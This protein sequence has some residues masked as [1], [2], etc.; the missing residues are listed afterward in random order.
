MTRYIFI[1]GGVVS[2]LGKGL[3]SAALGVLLQERNYK[4]K[5][6]KLDPYLNV[7]A[8]TMNP[9]QH[10]EVF[11]TDDKV[12][13]DMDLGHYER[14]TNVNTTKNDIITAGKIYQTLL[15]KERKGDY[16]GSTVQTIPHVTNLIK[17][18]ILKDTDDV[19]FVLAEI[20]GTVGDIEGLPFFESIRQIGYELGKNRAIFIHLTLVPY[21]KTANELKTKPTQHSV[22]TLCSIGIQPDILLCRSDHHIPKS[23]KEKIAAF[24]NV[25]KE[26]VIEAPDVKTIYQIPM[27]YH[28]Q[29]LDKRVLDIF[30]LP[31][32]KN[33]KSNTDNFIPNLNHW[34][35]ISDLILNTKQEITIAIIGKYVQL[36][37]AY[38]S[39]G[40]A[41]SHSGV[42]NKVKVNLKWIDSRNLNKKM[43]Q[44]NLTGVSGILIPGGFGIEGTEGKIIA[45][46]YARVNKIP[47]LG[48]CFGMQL[49]I[50]EFARNILGLKDASSTELSNCQ[51]PVIDIMDHWYQED[52]TEHK[53]CKDKLG[54]TMRIGA[55]DCK[56][57]PGSLA[58]EIYNNESIISE[59]HRHRYE[60][61]INYSKQFVAK[62]LSFSGMSIDGK[63]PEIVE[64][65][66]HP[67]YLGV[68]FHPELKSRPFTPHPIFVSLVKAT[69]NYKNKLN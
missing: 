24:C 14:F 35:K 45:I 27:T 10:G 33:L 1:T 28:K 37:S 66:D 11:V 5:L 40:E 56:L 62:G 19:D 68:Q 58:S 57:T 12:E 38:K 16:L 4:I 44:E 30:N 8:G 64:M 50:I 36:T 23:E 6:R 20:G 41:F 42:A 51:N 60:V 61:N 21:I 25:P 63:L 22:K 3:A 55:Y 9:T 54:G 29:G 48:I 39:I 65:K 49:M 47:I 69:I 52:N 26:S 15:E 17:E 46:E 2:S 13:A 43:L 32:A 31:K 59:R 34:E 18:F 53:S 67:W 7:D